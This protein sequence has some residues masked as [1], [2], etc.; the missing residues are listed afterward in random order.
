MKLINI[1]RPFT[2]NFKGIARQFGA[3]IQSVEHEIA[4]HWFVKAHSEVIEQEPISEPEKEQV[5]DDSK[6][7]KLAKKK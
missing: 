7:K 3:G 6:P 2:L 4:D 1:R 5:A